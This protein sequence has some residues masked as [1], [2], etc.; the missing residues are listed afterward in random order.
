MEH[1]AEDGSSKIV[2]GCLLPYTGRGVVQR[3]ITDLFVGI[4][5]PDGH[6]SRHGRMPGQRWVG[7][8]ARRPARTRT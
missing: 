2:E 7:L 1:V 6:S 3:I 5:P 8:T 4:P